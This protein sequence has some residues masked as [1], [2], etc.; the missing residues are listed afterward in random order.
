MNNFNRWLRS[1]SGTTTIAGLVVLA[2]VVAVVGQFAGWWGGPGTAGL[3]PL[4]EDSC[5]PTCSETDGRFLVLAGS[6][7]ASFGGFQN[8]AWVIVPKNGASD[9]FILSIF[10]GDSGGGGTSWY[11][12]NWDTMTASVT[13]TLYANAARDGSTNMVVGTWSSTE[14]SNN[15]WYD[16][17]IDNVQEA[18]DE[19]GDYV[20]RFV[21][22]LDTPPTKGVSSFKLKSPSAYISVAGSGNTDASFGLVGMVATMGDAQVIYPNYPDLANTTY[23]G[24]WEFYFTLPESPEGGASY[25]EIWN[26][27]ADRGTSTDP[28]DIDT[29]DP[30]TDGV[31]AWAGPAAVA[32]REGK[33][34]NPADDSISSI[35][36][37]EPSIQF[38]LIDPDGNEIG[39]DIDAGG[40]EEWEKFVVSTDPNSGAD[41]V[42]D[43]LPAGIYKLR[44][45]G[46]DLYNSIWMNTS[47][48]LFSNPPPQRC[49]P[50]QE[51]L[52]GGYAIVA[53]NPADC[54]GQQNGLLFHGTSYTQ[55]KGKA[56][57]NGCLR[58]VGTHLVEA[59]AVEYVKE[60]D[61]K[62]S[63]VK[64]VPDPYQVNTPVTVDVAAPNCS[65][66]AAKQMDGKDFKGEVNLDPGLYC[67]TGD[68]TMNAGDVVTGDD[69]TLYFLD[70]KV[71]INGGA[72]VNLSAPS[73]DDASPALKNIL[74]YVPGAA[75][76]GQ[77]VKI[78]GNSDSYFTGTIYAPGSDVDFLGTSHTEGCE[79]TQVIGWNVRIGGT[80]DVIFCYA[81][82]S[83][84][85]C[86]LP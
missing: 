3:P 6:N 50:G 86:E 68:V 55:L 44:I 57:S 12:G 85:I 35:F 43:N 66:P 46:L 16:I 2:L 13:Y 39:R 18:V 11:E 83:E 34:G 32:E 64:I 61:N 21:A 54:K 36:R 53:L 15:A 73:R 5:M 22:T 8:T 81:C 59:A 76:K 60:Y 71:T 25:I 29:D 79:N 70:G 40:T 20:Y 51:C 67:I 33:K 48:D 63:K 23:G 77:A 4:T 41:A 45:E 19:H 47:L 17:N 30:D 80:A 1:K 10:D 69:V 24:A 37:R 28:L 58:S 26:G 52:A 62:N 84:E 72:T 14:M 31:P 74:F 7:M 82:T 49:T 56:I 78:N 75:G 9:S 27:D 65:D 42:V 38:T